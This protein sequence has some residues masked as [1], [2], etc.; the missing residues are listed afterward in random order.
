MFTKSENYY[1][2]T[3]QLMLKA[4]REVNFD[5]RPQSQYLGLDSKFHTFWLSR[6]YPNISLH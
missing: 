5:Y 2:E 3:P 1:F 4:Y 6:L